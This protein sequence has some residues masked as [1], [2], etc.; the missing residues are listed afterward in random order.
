MKPIICPKCGSRVQ[1]IIGVQWKAEAHY[2]IERKEG[3]AVAYL[4]DLEKHRRREHNK[5]SFLYFFCKFCHEPFPKKMEK[6]I[7]Q[8]MKTRDLLN[9][10]KVDK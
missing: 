1:K 2:Y 3:R 8:H 6:E 9:K 10:L 7:W 5:E 4:W